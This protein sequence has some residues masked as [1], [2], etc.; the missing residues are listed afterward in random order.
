M[1]AKFEVRYEAR[2]FSRSE[3]IPL[4]D[5]VPCRELAEDLSRALEY[6]Q[7]RVENHKL[8]QA[9]NKMADIVDHS[10]LLDE[11]LDKA[12]DDLRKAVVEARKTLDL[13]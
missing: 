8:K 9:L 1:K 5:Q 7:I 13:R 10:L 6:Y 2:S 11:D 12:W 4:N 3:E